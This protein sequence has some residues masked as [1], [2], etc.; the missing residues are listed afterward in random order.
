MASAIQ[1]ETR[2]VT[3]E[4]SLAYGFTVGKEVII[5]GMELTADKVKLLM[6][7][8]AILANNSAELKFEDT[9]DHY[10]KFQAFCKQQKATVNIVF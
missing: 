6:G 9:L 7:Q 5:T 8:A 3:S 2:V 10:K 1:K 4:E